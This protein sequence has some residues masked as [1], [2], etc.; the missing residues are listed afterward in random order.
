MIHNDTVYVGKPKLSFKRYADCQPATKALNKIHLN[1]GFT[2]LIS[3]VS[4]KEYDQK[5]LRLIEAH[6]NTVVKTITLNEEGI[7][8]DCYIFY[9]NKPYFT[10]DNTLITTGVF[11]TGGSYIGCPET[12]WYL[13]Q[14]GLE[15]DN[16]IPG[17]A[18]SPNKKGWVAFSHRGHCIFKMYDMLF[19]EDWRPENPADYIQ[20]WGGKLSDV[21]L[22]VLED[23]DY[24]LELF[25]EYV[26]DY[27]PF[28]KRG[29][30]L[31]EH[32]HQ[33]RRAVRNLHLY[34]G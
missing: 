18:Y 1:L 20:Y 30:T 26:I 23:A 21:D 6:T 33:A 8:S 14:E 22:A 3:T 19:D 15:A 28:Q 7:I 27:I 13:Y 10:D 16:R 34:M 24:D 9:G 25:Q 12:G 29:A 32:M 2:K 4:T 31:I 5:K 17:I 11:T